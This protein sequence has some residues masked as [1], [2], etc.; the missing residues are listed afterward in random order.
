MNAP[1]SPIKDG[2]KV[3][4][5]DGYLNASVAWIGCL[6]LG[7]L[8][9]QGCAADHTRVALPVQELVV[10][11]QLVVHSDFHVPKRH[12]LLDEL[13]AR[14]HDISE[15][16]NLP[17]SDEPINIYLFKKGDE[18][19]EYMHREH[20]KFPDRRAFFLKNDTTLTVLAYW[21]DRVGEDLRHEVTH[22][23]LHSV[24]PNLPLWLDEG[25]AEYFETPRGKNGLNTPHIYHLANAF[26][27]GDW[28]PDLPRLE[29][30][31]DPSTMTQMDYAESWLWVHFMMESDSYRQLLQDQL[32]RLRL[33]AESKPI[34][35]FVESSFKNTEERLIEHLKMLG[36]ALDP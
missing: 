1:N 7:I 25:I 3:R 22:G 33:D 10:R 18:F 8:I 5:A 2:Y 9:F 23:Y 27:R 12:R 14:R 16:L 24:V 11:D 20:P 36:E 19:R 15:L 35:V 31:I 21:G 32:A 29:N 17:T 28:T 30:L 26:R 6:A 13:T 34:S 4:S